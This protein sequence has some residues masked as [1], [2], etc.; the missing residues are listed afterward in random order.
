MPFRMTVIVGILFVACPAWSQTEPSPSETVH[1][2]TIYESQ[3]TR[4]PVVR[5]QY[6]DGRLSERRATPEELQYYSDKTRYNRRT[7]SFDITNV[8]IPPLRAAEPRTE[9]SQTAAQ[10]GETPLFS[11]S[12]GT[13]KTLENVDGSS[14]QTA[15][16]QADSRTRSALERVLGVEQGTLP[17]NGKKCETTDDGFGNTSTS[18]RGSYTWTRSSKKD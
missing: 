14:T 15:E 10:W 13:G 5:T 7:T 16:E 1:N 17:E 9:P 18:C 2:I 8:D 4:T 12:S 3:I 6:K 11:G